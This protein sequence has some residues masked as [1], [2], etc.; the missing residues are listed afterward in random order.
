MGEVEY[1]KG[2][3]WMVYDCEACGCR[4]T[5]HDEMAHD[6][7][8]Q[9]GAIAYYEDY[10]RLAAE[11]KACFGRRDAEGLREVLSASPKYKFVIDQL[12][13]LPRD[14]R[15]LEIGCSRGYLTSWFILGG[16]D[17]LG[18]DVSAEAID[19]ARMNFG[20]HFA[21]AD[22][23]EVKA[24]APYDAIYHVGMIG[25]VRDPIGLT[26]QLLSLLK[27]GGLLCFNAPNRDAS[28]RKEQLWLD[29][30]PPP[31]LVTLFPPG[32]WTQRFGAEETVQEDVL[33]HGHDAS[34]GIRLRNLLGP[35]WRL[36]VPTDRFE[37]GEAR[38]SS[39]GKEG[40]R[41]WV[42]RAIAKLARVTGL[43]ALAKPWPTD[44]GLHITMRVKGGAPPC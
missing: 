36:P 3:R 30:A 11:C 8:H 7:L 12:S 31:D 20:E 33:M 14:S 43:S 35:A 13:P 29:S 21:M 23:P 9:A 16:W 4:F 39:A 18:V 10:R 22:A 38:D 2:F 17:I 27:P 40:V 6:R 5:K 24:R 25:C 1:L 37:P 41:N 26:R 28:R 44:F 19:S 15:L 42:I 32:F 34:S